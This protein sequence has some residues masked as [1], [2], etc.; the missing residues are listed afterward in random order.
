M[1]NILKD[2]EFE[3]QAGQIIEGYPQ[4]V[5][6]AAMPIIKDATSFKP[7][8]QAWLKNYFKSEHNVT[9]D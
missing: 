6:E 1:T 5:G 7:A 9:I 4:F 8:A 2:P 3:K